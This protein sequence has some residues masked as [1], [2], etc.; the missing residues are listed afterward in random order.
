MKVHDC[1]KSSELRSRSDCRIEGEITAEL[2]PTEQSN[3]L[4]FNNAFSA[5]FEYIILRN[6]VELQ[7]L[8]TSRGCIVAEVQ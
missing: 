8:D 7:F 5:N 2:K 1:M 4:S 6:D 3:Q